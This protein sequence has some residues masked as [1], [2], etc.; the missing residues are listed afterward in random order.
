MG[1]SLFQL[2]TMSYDVTALVRKRG[3]AHF[4]WSEKSF[5][6]IVTEEFLLKRGLFSLKKWGNEL[7]HLILFI[8]KRFPLKRSSVIRGFTVCMFM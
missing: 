8:L 7:V 3:H 5:R 6:Y 4:S 2:I 1:G